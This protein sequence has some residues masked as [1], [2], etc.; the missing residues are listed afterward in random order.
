MDKNLIWWLVG[1]I[2]ILGLVWLIRIPSKSS[3]Y[4]TFASCIN[5]SGTL[6]YGTFWCPVC[7]N[8]KANF[9]SSAKLLPYI[10]CSTADGKSQLP[11]CNEAGITGYPT[12]VF[13]DGSQEKGNIPLERLSELTSCS[14]PTEETGL[15]AE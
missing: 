10:E 5:D 1:M 14:L 7:K 13:P 4:D 2:I 8:Q 3:Q 11:I 6:F 15:P 12:W 9:G